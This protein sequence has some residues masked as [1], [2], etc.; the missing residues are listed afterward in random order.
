M[1]ASLRVV[2]EVPSQPTIQPA[3]IGVPSCSSATT[4]SCSW[5]SPV[6]PFPQWGVVPSSA[7]R[8]R[9]AASTLAWDTTIGGAAVCIFGSPNSSVIN[10]RSPK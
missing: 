3:R 5:R 10:G 1:P 8:A 6:S 9:S 4:W 7:R 2:L